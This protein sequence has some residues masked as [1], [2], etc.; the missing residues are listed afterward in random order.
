MALIK[1]GFEMSG[2][3]PET[4]SNFYKIGRMLGKGAFGKVNMAVH[5]LS[6]RLVAIKCLNK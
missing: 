4:G 2:E 3:P 6:N 1:R 5:R